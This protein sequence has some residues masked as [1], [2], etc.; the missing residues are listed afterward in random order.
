MPDESTDTRESNMVDSCDN[1]FIDIHYTCTRHG[2]DS[3]KEKE[4]NERKEKDK[5]KIQ[6]E[7]HK[8]VIAAYLGTWTAM[9]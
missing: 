7:M 5:R 1:P 6:I 9:E 3:E 2:G 4:N 8:L